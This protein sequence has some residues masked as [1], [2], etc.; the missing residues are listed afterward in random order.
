MAKVVVTGITGFI[1]SH[2][3]K[4][5]LELDH[6][7]YGIIRASA[8]RS[9]AP[10]ED[11]LDSVI[12]L[13]ADITDFMSIANALKTASPDYVC[14]LAALSPVRLSFERPFDFEKMNYLG[15]MNIVH[16][17]ID[18]PDYRKRK[19]IAASTAEVY[20]I[21][22]DKRP[23]SED[24]RLIPS[25]PY[26]VSKVAADMYLRMAAKVYGLDIVILRPTN[27]FGRKFER[28]FLVEYLVTSMLQGNKVYVG[29][30]DSIR[31]YLYIDD[32]VNGY[33][34]AMKYGKKG[35]VYNLGGQATTNKDLA[36]KIAQKIGFDESRII[37]GVYPPGY[38]LRPI[39]SDQPYIMLDS[40]KAK[41]EL[42]WVPKVSIDEGLNRA[43]N[44]WRS[45]V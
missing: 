36:K 45:H 11:I 24:S 22:T 17:M 25:S 35:Q 14:H 2:L 43:I 29:A 6:I 44:Y 38:P 9:L 15:T 39:K 32:H 21:H 12:L 27:T 28:N 19:L 30:A 26:A 13:T 8:S 34:Q 3:A 18:L 20:G 37:F 7:V 40:T 31:E 41:N 42:K 5:L 10:I 16:A 33:I 4:R 23:L 1:G